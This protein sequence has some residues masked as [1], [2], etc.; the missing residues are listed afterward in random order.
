MAT[1]QSAKNS[2][3]NQ[4]GAGLVHPFGHAK[5]PRSGSNGAT[6]TGPVVN[7]VH[8]NSAVSAKQGM[9][10]STNFFTKGDP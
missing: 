5:N 9:R 10:S 3:N 4:M 6:N 1:D 7:H 8:S 2:C